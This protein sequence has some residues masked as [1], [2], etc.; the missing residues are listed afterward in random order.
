MYVDSTLTDIRDGYVNVNIT[1]INSSGEDVILLQEPVS[2]LSDSI[3]IKIGQILRGY[4]NGSIGTYSG[5]KLKIDGKSQ[6]SSILRILRQNFNFICCVY[7]R[8]SSTRETFCGKQ[9][10]TFCSLSY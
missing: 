3:E 8:I 4:Q 1:H 9:K 10:K 5:L 6:D 2:S 7:D